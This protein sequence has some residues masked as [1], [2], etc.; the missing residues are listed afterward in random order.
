MPLHLFRE[1]TAR[2]LSHASLAGTNG[3]GAISYLQFAEDVRDVVAHRV[4]AE[5]E[6]CGD[7]GIGVTL[8][9]EGEDFALGQFEERLWRRKRS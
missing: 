2:A 8:G 3:Q 6:A 7:L 9:D 5:D 4:R 1:I